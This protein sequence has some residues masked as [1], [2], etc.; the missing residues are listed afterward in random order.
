MKLPSHLGSRSVPIV[1][2]SALLAACMASRPPASPSYES[3]SRQEAAAIAISATAIPWSSISSAF[4]PNFTI[5]GD[6]A[7]SDVA[8]VVSRIQEQ[9]LDELAF[10]AQLGIGRAASLSQPAGKSEKPSAKTSDDTDSTA[11]GSQKG[12]TTTSS[13]S[14]PSSSNG[15]TKGSAQP[16]KGSAQ[17]SATSTSDPTL[18]PIL[19]YQA[20]LA[21]YQEVQLLNNEIQRIAARNCYAPF[22]VHIKVAIL[23]YKQQLP[24]DLHARIAFFGKVAPGAGAQS[25]FGGQMNSASTSAESAPLGSSLFGSSPGYTENTQ[26]CDDDRGRQLMPEVVPILVT[27]DVERAV[28]S[29]TLETARELALALNLLAPAAS[30]G[31]A[32][33]DLQQSL[34]SNLGQQ[35][36]SRLTVT[37]QANNTLYA[38]IG[39]AEDPT[40]GLN[41]IGQT[42]D[43]S[44][45]L[46]VPKLYFERMGPYQSQVAEL[47]VITYSELRNPRT[48]ESLPDTQK[49][50]EELST[51]SI[52]DA[53]QDV[54][55]SWAANWKTLT[56]QDKSKA[57][58]ISNELLLGIQRSDFTLFSAALQQAGAVPNDDDRY[59]TVWTRL[60]Q[61]LSDTAY[62]STIIELHGP[63][64]ISFVIPPEPIA[65][66][67]DGSSSVV[68]L[69]GVNGITS[70]GI[71]ARL[72]IQAPVAVSLDALSVVVDPKSGNLVVTFPSLKASGISESK[73]KASLVLAPP[74]CDRVLT[75]CPAF[76]GSLPS[77]T[78]LSKSL[79]VTYLQKSSDTKKVPPVV[80][81]TS[82][83]TAIDSSGGA[84]LVQF[85]IGKFSS[86]SVASVQVSVTGAQ[87]K[88]ATDTGGKSLAVTDG[89]F[90][91]TKPG[92]FTLSLFNLVPGGSVSI[93]AEALDASKKSLGK[94]VLTLRVP[95][96]S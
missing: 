36:N 95:A 87:V 45:L 27:D 16:S 91:T 58:A 52:E 89:K 78:L 21:L 8:P 11:D 7:V 73:I 86:P 90:S 5:S 94:G 30:A 50:A 85:S 71:N 65:L 26:T 25:G 93:T 31:A 75:L 64:P 6:A 41:L 57:D 63:A 46:L 22:M 84:G 56:Q 28:K 81:V 88:S 37:R 76:Q 96:K 59:R 44:A 29:K 67:D 48:G 12:E 49:S 60:T 79:P 32:L 43:I 38:R 4:E 72:V 66:L 10:S 3:K 35:I 40:S 69:S 13:P 24:Y 51:T 47:Q 53:L 33:H 19:K 1:A 70:S 9:V 20:A 55:Q 2:V 54:N 42:Y 62:G 77:A 34:S 82:T 17:P 23:P 68:Q 18:D 92:D 80:S 14:S 39:A 15:S 61:L 74:R 83:A